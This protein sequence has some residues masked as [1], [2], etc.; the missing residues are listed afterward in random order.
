MIAIDY[1]I[2]GSI[3]IFIAFAILIILAIREAYDMGYG[4]GLHTG[5]KLVR[6]VAKEGGKIIEIRTGQARKDEKR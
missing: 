4:D 1:V 6:H 5:Y 2:K 3:L